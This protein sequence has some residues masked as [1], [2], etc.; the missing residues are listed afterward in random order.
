MIHKEPINDFYIY[1]VTFG[2]QLVSAANALLIPAVITFFLAGLFL[3]NHPEILFIWLPFIIPILPIYFNYL[4]ED[5][6]KTV[7][8]NYMQK[9]LIVSQ[10]NQT[11]KVTFEDIDSIK[12]VCPIFNKWIYPWINF[13]YARFNFK[14]GG[15]FIITR[16]ILN[17]DEELFTLIK[18]VKKED[19]YYP[20]IREKGKVLL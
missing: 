7:K 17:F 10:Y 16:F 15:Y 20:V 2:Q 18:N 13:K 8:I 6:E 12:I 9:L 3:P 1:E 14:S 19:R 4:K 11:I 5:N